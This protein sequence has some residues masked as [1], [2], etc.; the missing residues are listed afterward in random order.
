MVG[1][2]VWSSAACLVPDGRVRVARS[3]AGDGIGGLHTIH[4]VGTQNYR[5]IADHLPA[6]LA[7]VK[8]NVYWLAFLAIVATPV[9]LLLAY[10]AGQADPHLYLPKHL[11]LPVVP[12]SP[13][14]ASSGS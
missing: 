10:F 9:G 8:H 3:R 12:R 6:V 4:W 7:A 14:S 2:P 11:L 13:S 5:Q 1:I